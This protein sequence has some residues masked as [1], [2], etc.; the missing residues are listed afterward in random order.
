LLQ[1]YSKLSFKLVVPIKSC[2]AAFIPGVNFVRIYV[3]SHLLKNRNNNKCF[4]S[5][6]RKPT[7]SPTHH[8]HRSHTISKMG[9]EPVTPNGHHNDI[10]PQ[11]HATNLCGYDGFLHATICS[12]LNN[13]NNVHFTTANPVQFVSTPN[14]FIHHHSKKSR[15]KAHETAR[16]T[17]QA[18]AA[19]RHNNTP[20]KINSTLLN[21]MSPPV[22]TTEQKMNRSLNHVEKWLERDHLQNNKNIKTDTTNDSKYHETT[23]KL[24]TNNENLKNKSK[25]QRSKSKEEIMSKDKNNL[26]NPDIF[27]DKLKITENLAETSVTPKKVT[28]KDAAVAPVVTAT[29]K[30]SSSGSSSSKITPSLPSKTAENNSKNTKNVILEYS[31]IPVNAEPIECEN[32]LRVTSDDDTLN[33]DLSTD[34]TVHQYVHIHHHYHHFE[35]DEC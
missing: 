21:Q 35:N 10:T 12:N 27:L 13:N 2:T 7:E 31:T 22:L 33:N 25:L 16:L 28:N 18:A 29:K 4:F 8:R 23:N 14:R 1:L 3:K 11:I 6:I 30:T 9:D 34:S 5:F 20:M 17:T 26:V 15:V 19:A 32:L 24:R